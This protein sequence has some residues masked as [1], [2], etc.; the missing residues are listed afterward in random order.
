MDVIK[1]QHGL[2][3]WNQFGG[4]VYIKGVIC[5]YFDKSNQ[6]HLPSEEGQG[7]LDFNC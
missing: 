2:A 5:F 1:Y 3:A 6:S 4:G 7:W